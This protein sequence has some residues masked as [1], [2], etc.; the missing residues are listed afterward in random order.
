[1]Q[2]IEKIFLLLPEK[3]SKLTHDEVFRRVNVI[4]RQCSYTLLI[5]F[6]VFGSRF[7]EFET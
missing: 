2:K 3:F 6:L 1:M 7:P 5:W 4:V